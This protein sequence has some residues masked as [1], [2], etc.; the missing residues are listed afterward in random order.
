MQEANASVPE[1]NP[2]LEQRRSTSYP[3]A[4]DVVSGEFG[5]QEAKISP[6]TTA[7]PA[8]GP[9]IPEWFIMTPSG[10]AARHS[11]VARLTGHSRPPSGDQRID[12]HDLT[13]LVLAR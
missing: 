9:T 10:S 4:P 2:Y 6:R 3:A 7:A 5:A 1:E 11:D 12:L 13:E 8:I